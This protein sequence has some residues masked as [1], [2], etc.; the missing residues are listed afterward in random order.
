MSE[1]T[2]DSPTIL[3]VMDNYVSLQFDRELIE[4][5]HRQR[6]HLEAADA[7]DLCALFGLFA[8]LVEDVWEAEPDVSTRASI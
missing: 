6:P 7:P 1:P 5:L 3:R 2:G 8:Q 4:R